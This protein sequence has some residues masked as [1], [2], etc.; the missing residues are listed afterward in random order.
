MVSGEVPEWPK[1]TG[2]KPVGV[3]LRRFESSPPHQYPNG[4]N[5]LSRFNCLSG[6]KFAV[7]AGIAQLARAPAFQAGGRGFE[8]RFPLQGNGQSTDD[9]GQKSDNSRNTRKISQ[10]VF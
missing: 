7:Q 9:R 6:F 3:S 10:S 4:L 2:C 8:S 1:G 5:S